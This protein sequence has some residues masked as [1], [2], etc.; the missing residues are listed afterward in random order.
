MR[1]RHTTPSP[2][3]VSRGTKL[4]LRPYRYIH[5][6]GALAGLL[7]P[8]HESAVSGKRSNKVSF[9]QG[10]DSISVSGHKMLGCPMPCG[11]VITRKEHM[12]RFARD[13]E[14]L[15]ST[16]STIMGS[17]NG[18]ASLAMWYA[19]QQKN[20]VEGLIKEAGKCFANAKFLFDLFKAEGVKCMLNDYSTTVVFEKPGVKVVK[21]W[22]LACK[23]DI[24][25]V[26]VMPSSGKSKLTQFFEA[27]MA[28]R[29]ERLGEPDAAQASVSAVV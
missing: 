18:Q 11:V 7:L 6:D 17:R 28:D 15:N 29:K 1:A 9:K 27:Y 24:A 22:Q 19:L 4:T 14:Y 10:I 12:Q 20:G 8:F 13:V 16:D 2:R 5:C 23:G 26:V 25:H 3:N 21:E